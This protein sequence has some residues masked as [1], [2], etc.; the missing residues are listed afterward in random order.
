MQVSI[1]IDLDDIELDD[2][3]ENLEDRLKYRTDKHKIEEFCKDVIHHENSIPRDTLLDVMKLELIQNNI[4][5]FTL[6]EL[7]TFFKTK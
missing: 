3:L 7:E 5:K 6:D 1:D 4:H 2:L